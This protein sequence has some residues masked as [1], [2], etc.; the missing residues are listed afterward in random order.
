MRIKGGGGTDTFKCL[1]WG[2]M[3]NKHSVCTSMKRNHA[4]FT[5][6]LSLP[7]NQDFHLRRSKCML[8]RE[9]RVLLRA[10]KSG[11]VFKIAVSPHDA[12]LCTQ[13]LSLHSGLQ[14]VGFV[15]GSGWNGDRKRS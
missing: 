4:M 9:H 12:Q 8:V 11:F 5:C 7:D 2:I 6:R 15:W 14:T 3:L 13:H 10:G 1:L